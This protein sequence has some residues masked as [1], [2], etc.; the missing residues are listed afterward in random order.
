MG[1][2]FGASVIGRAPIEQFRDIN[3]IKYALIKYCKENFLLQ[4][5]DGAIHILEELRK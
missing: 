1:F 5:L 2:I 3:F 4:A